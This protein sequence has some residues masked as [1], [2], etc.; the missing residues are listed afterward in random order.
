MANRL[1]SL[2]FAAPE[3][4]QAF[5]NNTLASLPVTPGRRVPDEEIDLLAQIRA[6][7]FSASEPGGIWDA[8]LPH[9]TVDGEK[10]TNG[11]FLSDLDGWTDTST[12][13]GTAAWSSGAAELVRTDAANSGILRQTIST[14][15]GGWHEVEFLAAD[16]AIKCGVGTSALDD[17]LADQT[18]NAGTT[19]AFGFT[20]TTATT[21]VYFIPT[22]DATTARL[23]RVSVKEI[24]LANVVVFADRAGTT[25]ASL[26]GVIGMVL[27][28]RFGLAL[29]AEL[30]NGTFDTGITG[31]AD[32]AAGADMSYAWDAANQRISVTRT[33]AGI[34]NRPAHPFPV[35][36][37]KFYKFV[38]GANGGNDAAFGFANSDGGSIFSGGGAQTIGT[39]A[40]KSF[41]FQ[42]SA[43]GTAYL[44]LWCAVGSTW[45]DNISVRE[46]PGNHLVAPTDANRPLW[47]AREN[48]LTYTEQFDNAVWTKEGATV[49]SNVIVGP[50]GQTTADKLVEDTTVSGTNHRAYNNSNLIG[51]VGLFTASIYA[52]AGERSQFHLRMPGGSDAQYVLFN[53]ETET[54][55]D[56]TDGAGFAT[57]TSVGDGW[58]RCS[59]SATTD[60]SIGSYLH[61][62]MHDDLGNR[63]YTGDGVSGMYFSD[64]QFAP[65]PNPKNY[66]R[67]AAADDYDAAGWPRYALGDGVNKMLQAAYAITYPFDVMLATRQVSYIS[68]ALLC[69][70][71][72]NAGGSIQQLGGSP[73]IRMFS[74]TGLSIDNFDIGL[75]GIITARFAEAE[76]KLA[77]NNEE[78]VEG[79]TGSYPVGGVTL[80]ALY[81][82]SNFSNTRLYRLVMREGTLTDDQIA[83]VRQWCNEGLNVL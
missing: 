23:N 11:E 17:S 7:G 65:G 14:T 33:G 77:L 6:F 63:V 51:V 2:P 16:A 39:T 32:F 53:L 45:F 52:K 50:D 36:A 10:V 54:Y 46:L 58:Y 18:G 13:A 78:Y 27:D 55:I 62:C 69:S 67:V 72:T 66:Q 71:V 61:V 15:P 48:L 43:T 9:P 83:T 28:K 29:G 80:F 4:T 42:A 41:I 64:G 76:S 34:N 20:A 56:S 59:V 79:D 68:G 8:T 22:T 5:G 49:S 19:K 12:G 57:I 47:S 37:G 74:G 31:W 73:I 26:N 21:H 82:G 44:L 75:D 81:D 25:P 24:D 38:I 60:G 35:T 30:V 70:G 1:L 40:S 3:L